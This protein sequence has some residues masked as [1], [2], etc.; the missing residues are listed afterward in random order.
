MAAPAQERSL[1]ERQ[2]DA[3]ALRAERRILEKIRPFVTAAVVA[4]HRANPVGAH[5]L[6]LDLILGYLRRHGNPAMDQLMIV[7]TGPERDFHV[8]ARAEGDL[9][10]EMREESYETAAAATH[11]IF[12]E[13]LASL[14][15]EIRGEGE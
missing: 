4:E 3:V 14:G 12:L 5:S 9:P 6:E 8:A 11:Q 15:L 2:E 7:A 1:L 10:I 13:R